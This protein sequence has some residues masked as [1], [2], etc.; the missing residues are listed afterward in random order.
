MK[1]AGQRVAGAGI[2]AIAITF[3]ITEAAKAVAVA[4]GQLAQAR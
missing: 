2:A 4:W 1:G 3:V